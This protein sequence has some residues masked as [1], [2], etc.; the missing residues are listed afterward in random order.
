MPRISR[1]VAVGYPHHITARNWGHTNCV[2]PKSA[3]KPLG[4]DQ[5]NHVESQQNT[6]QNTQKI[7]L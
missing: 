5:A 7:I 6:S 1:A 3:I 4:S 2:S